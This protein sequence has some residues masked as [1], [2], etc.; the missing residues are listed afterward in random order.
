MTDNTISESKDGV[1]RIKLSKVR[2]RIGCFTEDNK[3][4]LSQEK[5]CKQVPGGNRE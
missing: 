1:R 5:M 4:D 2:G 3:D